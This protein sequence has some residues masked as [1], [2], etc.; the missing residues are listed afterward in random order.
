MVTPSDRLPKKY[1]ILRLAVFLLGFTTI[2]MFFFSFIGITIGLCLLFLSKGRAWKLNGFVLAFSAAFSTWIAHV[3][4]ALSPLILAAVTGPVITVGYLLMKGIG[5]FFYNRGKIH[6]QLPHFRNLT[7]KI[8]PRWKKVLFLGIGVFPVFL[9]T[10]VSIDFGVMFDNSP[11]VLWVHAP[12]TANRSVNFNVTVESWDPYERLSAI[13]TGSVAFSLES[14]NRTTYA[15]LSSVAA[16]LPPS[17]VFTGQT[18]GSDW[19]YEIRD[20]KDNGRHVFSVNISTRGIHYIRV[21]DSLSGHVFYSNPVLVDEW[22]AGDLQIYWG[23]LHTHSELSDGTGTPEHNFYYGRHVA[24]LD[25]MAL[26]DHGEILLLQPGVMDR[27]EKVVN[28]AYSPQQFVAFQGIEWTQVQT[29][30][31]TCIFSGDQGLDNPVSFLTHPLTS[32]LWAALDWFT[33]ATGSRALALPHHT[34]KKAYTQDW[35]YL[36]PKY[37]KLAEVSSVHGDFLYEQRDALNYRGAIDPPVT[38]QNGTSI[39]DS[40]RMGFNLTLYASSDVHDGHPGHSLSHTRAFVGHQ[41]PLSMWHTRNEH[42]YPS[43]I[44]AIYATSLTRDAVFTG[45]ENQRIYASSDYGRPFLNFSI[46]GTSFLENNHQIFTSATDHRAI[47]IVV[48]Q[49]GAYTARTR[50]SPIKGPEW[51]LNWSATIEILKNGELWQTIP[52]SSPIYNITIVD[53]TPITGAVYGAQSCIQRDG[54]YYINDY[55][56]NPIDPTTL[57]TSGADFYVMRVIGQGGRHAYVGPIWVSHL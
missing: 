46:N 8:K 41:R 21:T 55:S 36:N 52:I 4:V 22:E 30:H 51:A 12:T 28:D 40:L 13:Y 39:M 9:W 10:S 3:S 54:K 6:F 11:Q 49:D 24:C 42:P 53:T 25:V 19:A 2:F 16:E 31:Y 48:A 1:Q 34:T 27:L 33:S 29:G 57:D 18:F 14:Y 20:G 7:G 32:D 23:D 43:G 38:R 37:V 56:D 15:Q 5:E 45:L 50:Q 26:T 47:S 17:Y 35:T 44:T